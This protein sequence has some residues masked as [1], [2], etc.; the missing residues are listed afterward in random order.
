MIK[1]I[2]TAAFI[3]LAML[4]YGCA[5]NLIGN[6][7]TSLVG[8]RDVALN[9]ANNNAKSIE[10]NEA[11]TENESAV[12]SKEEN[13]SLR[14]ILRKSGDIVE[15]DPVG[16]DD[17]GPELWI[18]DVNTSEF[19]KTG[20]ETL[21]VYS[22]EAA[23]SRLRLPFT[24]PS[25][26]PGDTSPDCIRLLRNAGEEMGYGAVTRYLIEINEKAQKNS[27][28]IEYAYIIFV[29]LDVGSLALEEVA[30]QST[31]NI[32]LYADSTR[33]WIMVGGEEAALSGRY[34]SV[35][36][37]MEAPPDEYIVDAAIHW[38]RG[39]IYYQ[40]SVTSPADILDLE[41]MIAIAESIG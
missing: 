12:S 3:C 11:L 5:G 36:L 16:D 31:P 41:T 19:R 32:D 23:A 6:Q 18:L 39:N 1:R 33:E 7:I 38:S 10:E 26:I 40:L 35:L 4:S 8:N 20:L 29:Q 15:K 28:S 24:L 30:S 14:N 27:Y 22:A 25:F 9:K 34:L 2:I 21:N 17:P 37:G 13:T